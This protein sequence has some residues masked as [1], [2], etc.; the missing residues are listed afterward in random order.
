MEEAGLVTR[1][2]ST[3]DRR[4]VTTQIT[5]KGRDLVNSLDDV[6]ERQHKAQ[7]GH[8]SDKELRTLIDLLTLVRNAK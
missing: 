3:E 7:L 2:R 4:L 5:D 6:V 1:A 8:L